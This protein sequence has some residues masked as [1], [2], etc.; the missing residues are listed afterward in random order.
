[1]KA[2]LQKIVDSANEEIVSIRR[3]QLTDPIRQAEEARVINAAR[4]FA[5]QR[6]ESTVRHLRNM[7]AKLAAENR[8]L[9]R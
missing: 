3:A 4:A 8:P 9:R 1:L 5:V 6:V 2:D 7:A